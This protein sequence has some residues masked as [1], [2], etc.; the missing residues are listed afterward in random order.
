MIDV[1]PFSF[2]HQVAA[3][4]FVAIVWLLTLLIAI[5][6]PAAKKGVRFRR[7]DVLALVTTIAFGASWAAVLLWPSETK[8]ETRVTAKAT[9][10]GGAAC[11]TI[12]VGDTEA[13]VR[14][15]LGAPAQTRDEQ[16]LRG[17]GAAAW[18]YPDSRCAV[19]MLAGKVESVE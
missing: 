3:M 4:A 1:G 10:S 17:P 19:H 8:A 16:D 12:D 18:I 6:A 11:A 7:C 13:E 9:S 15:R 14:K 5:V 2:T